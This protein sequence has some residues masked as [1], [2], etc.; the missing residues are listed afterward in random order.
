MIFQR[1]E[2]G[3]FPENSY[4]ICYHTS[5]DI[6]WSPHLIIRIVHNRLTEICRSSAVYYTPVA[7]KRWSTNQILALVTLRVILVRSKFTYRLIVVFYGGPNNC[8]P[9]AFRYS[10]HFDC[11]EQITA[12]IWGLNVSYLFTL[13]FLSCHKLD[14][15][16]SQNAI[17][18]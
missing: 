9:S 10:Y 2:R 8:Y 16:R 6:H 12:W 3:K 13:S 17:F 15:I 18:K 4:S 14:L 1:Q 7:C 5:Y 11:S